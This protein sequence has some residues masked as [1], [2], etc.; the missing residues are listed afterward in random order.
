MTQLFSLRRRRPAAFTLIELL[1]VIAI[2]AILIGLLLPAV[3]KVREAAARMRCQNNLKQI[4]IAMHSYHDVRSKFP[5]G[6][7][8]GTGTGQDYQPWP[9]NDNNGDWNSD[10][11]N[12]IVYSLPYLEQD[13]LYKGINPR[14]NVYNSVHATVSANPALQPAPKYIRCPSDDFD[15]NAKVTNYVG[16][17]GPQCSIGPYGFDPNQQYCTTAMGWGYAT[18]PDHGNDWSSNGI[19]G[20]FNRLGAIIN[21]AMAKDGLSNTILIG[22]S[23]PKHHDHLAGG[24]W[25]H[26]NSSGAAHCSTIVPINQR[27]DGP[28]CPGTAQ[29]SC[30]SNWN[31]SFGFKS[32]HSGGAN[33]LFGDGS[34]RFVS[35]S[36]EHRTYQ[37]LGARDDG[38]AVNL[39]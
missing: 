28:S 20:M 22:E 3:Q 25:W 12:W 2:I 31:I 34:V 39:P 16:S 9:G 13:N 10:Q 30:P 4:G 5:P 14:A 38:L 26:F 36:I 37:L 23:L 7:A 15:P 11:G 17:M 21:M 8:M 32:N 33:F 1:V 27:S 6:G 18:S 35:Q 24:A 19:R 29:Q